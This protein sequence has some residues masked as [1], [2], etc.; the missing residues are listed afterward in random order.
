MTKNN[1]ENNIIKSENEE[2]PKK[3]LTKNYDN[4]WPISIFDL[5]DNCI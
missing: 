2:I 1:D 3:I 4:N 5:I